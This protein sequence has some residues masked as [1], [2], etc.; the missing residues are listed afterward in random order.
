MKYEELDN[1]LLIAGN[2]GELKVYALYDTLTISRQDTAQVSH[3]HHNGRLIERLEATQMD[4]EELIA[5]HK[6][7]S[8]LVTDH[9]GHFE[10]LFGGESGEDHNL[11]NEIVHEL[12]KTI[13]AE[14]DRI[15]QKENKKWILVFPRTYRK[16]LV[17]LLDA[18][19]VDLLEKTVDANLVKEDPYSIVEKHILKS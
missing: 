19:A 8:E 18:K 13:S 17:G 6:K 14:I 1:K 16:Q 2:L 11:E 4:D 5:A 9:A 3:K 7:I 15:V 10:G 12:L